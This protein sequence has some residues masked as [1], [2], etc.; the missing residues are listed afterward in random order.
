MKIKPKR[1]ISRKS[2]PH[3]R[4]NKNTIK[5]GEFEVD[6]ELHDIILGVFKNQEKD[7]RTIIK[8]FNG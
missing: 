7:T 6:K 5:I 1:V 3:K 2:K 4:A 8:G